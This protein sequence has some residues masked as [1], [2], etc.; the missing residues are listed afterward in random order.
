MRA[1][2]DRSLAG[3]LSVIAQKTLSDLSLKNCTV[4]IFL[5]SGK[6]MRD[7]EEK[8]GMRRANRHT[9]NVLSFSE[10]E[11]FPHPETEGKLIG[12]VYLNKDLAARGFDGLAYLL[13]H[14][15]LHIMGYSH[16]EKND[17][18]KMEALEQEICKK[19]LQDD[20]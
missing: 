13:I 17:I 19:V 7:F 5:L 16:E 12:E 1:G 2:R 10:P 14:G 18:L 4:K 8:T 6:E 15:I 20:K 9:P 3:R 11:G